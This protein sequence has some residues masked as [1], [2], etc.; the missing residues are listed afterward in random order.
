MIKAI[1]RKDGKILDEQ[2]GSDLESLQ[3]WLAPF[4]QSGVYGKPANSIRQLVS[5]AQE[6]QPAIYEDIQIPAEYQIEFVDISAE[7]N[8]AQIN[9]EA[10]QFLAETDWKI[11]RHVGQQSLGLATTLTSQEYQELEHERQMAREAII[12]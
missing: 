9:N 12:Q 11:L 3:A 4:E 5:E 10:L 8:Q 2:Q 1:I 6:D 7:L